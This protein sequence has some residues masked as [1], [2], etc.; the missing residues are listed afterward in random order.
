MRRSLFS[1]GIIVLLL[2]CTEVSY[3]KEKEF[4]S[5]QKPFS[6]ISL[7]GS[8]AWCAVNEIP[9]TPSLEN[10]FFSAIPSSKINAAGTGSPEE[11]KTKVESLYETHGF[12]KAVESSIRFFSTKIK[13]R[14]SNSLSRSGKFFSMMTDIF[15]EKGLPQELVFL[16]LIESGFNMHAYSPMKASGLW[17]FIASTGKRYGLKIDWWVDERRDPIK[18]TVAA[19]AYLSDL[20]NMF[21]SWN[22]ALAAYNAGEGKITKAL[23]RTKTDDFWAIRN[24]RHIK[25]ET[26]DYV[27]FYIAATAIAVDPE[28]F[29]FEDLTYHE[30]LAYDEVV[31][32]SPMDI[33]AIARYAE[34]DMQAVKDLN[35]ELK[36]W[37]T[38]PNVSNYALRL[39]LGT[40]ESFLANLANSVEDKHFSME[41]YTVK[42]GDTL[43]NVAGRFGISK[44]AIAGVNSLNSNSKLEAGSTILVPPK[45]FAHLIKD[46]EKKSSVKSKRAYKKKGKKSYLLSSKDKRKKAR[47]S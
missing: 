10:R 32:D 18:A 13:E 17:Q 9:F 23:N 22:L 31:I 39:P 15:K 38:P 45:E 7:E 19:A 24:T 37:C 35:P 34:V 2:L 36:R 5:S 46:T 14:F 40:K 26:K 33:K 30:P 12:N 42:K 1:L 4:M 16:P 6:E 29:G 8:H 20:Y 21:G 25:K 41:Y 43:K 44:D 3:S 28:G 47:P 11:R 27:P